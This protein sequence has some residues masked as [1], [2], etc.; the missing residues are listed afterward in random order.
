MNKSEI[1][2][3]SNKIFGEFSDYCL[4]ISDAVFFKQPADK[5]S[6]AQNVDHI[7]ISTKQTKLAY[8]LPK[9]IVR[10]YTGKPNRPSRSYDELVVKYKLKLENGGRASGNSKVSSLSSISMQRERSCSECSCPHGQRGIPAVG[11]G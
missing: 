5:W 3:A 4:N 8:L 7:I 6:V 1:I 10:L 11:G 9:F 2:V